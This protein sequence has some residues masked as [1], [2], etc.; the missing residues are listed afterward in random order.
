MTPPAVTL[1]KGKDGP[2]GQNSFL[3]FRSLR[4]PIHPATSM[5]GDLHYYELRRHWTKRIVPHLSDES[6]NAILVRD[7]NKYTWGRWR[8]RFK[9]GDLPAH[10][11]SC[12]WSL[13]HHPPH[14]RYWGYVK[15]AACHWLVNF[16]LRLA[17]LA[18]P[19]RPWRIITSDRHST[20]WDGKRTL[21]DFN[22]LALRISPSECFEMASERELAPGK[23]LKVHYARHYSL[24][25]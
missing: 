17:S 12:D 7:F 15:H 11:E 2:G 13:D 14:P 10:F 22:F 19:V 23:A 16:S 9:L 3:S 21:F 20:V 4:G 6:L 25:Q 1:T 18:E 8:T 5:I 24:D